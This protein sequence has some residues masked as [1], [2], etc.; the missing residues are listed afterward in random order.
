MHTGI[1][2]VRI[3]LCC[4]SCPPC[5]N[6]R[7]QH[8][9]LALVSCTRKSRFFFHSCPPLTLI[10]CQEIAIGKMIPTH[11]N[12]PVFV[13]WCATQSREPM[14]MW[15]LIHGHNLHQVFAMHRMRCKEKHAMRPKEKYVLSWSRQLFSALACLHHHGAICT[16][17]PIFSQSHGLT[18]SDRRNCANTRNCAN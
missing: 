12:L 8:H 14:V 5:I 17:S 18:G 6:P 11:P 3:H 2:L 7:T 16:I 13:G 10:S 9:I 4:Y 1:G 15:K